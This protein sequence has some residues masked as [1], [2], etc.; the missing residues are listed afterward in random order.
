M[1]QLDARENLLNI[2]NENS[3]GLQKNEMYDWN[4]TLVWISSIIIFVI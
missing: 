3:V 4:P 2:L 1:P